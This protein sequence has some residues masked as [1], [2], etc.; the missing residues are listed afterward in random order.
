MTPTVIET[1]YVHLEFKPGLKACRIWLEM[2][3]EHAAM[4]IAMF[5][6]PDPANPV[7]VALARIAE[8]TSKA[9]GDRFYRELTP[10]QR[11]ALL[12]ARPDFVQWLGCTDVE[13]AATHIRGR[14]GIKSRGEL[15]RNERAAAEWSRIQTS[16][17]VGEPYQRVYSFKSG[18]GKIAKFKTEAVW[19][20]ELSR[21]TTAYVGKRPTLAALYEANQSVLHEIIARAQAHADE[22]TK[23]SAIALEQRIVAALNVGGDDARN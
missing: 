11:C 18:D 3:I 10:S 17:E 13:D 22:A 14:L 5:G 16:F 2:P 4:F 20:L 19:L 15:D 23:D 8:E 9:K 21:E 12:C 7:R 1:R 6:T